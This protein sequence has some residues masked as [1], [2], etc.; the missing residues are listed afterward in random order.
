[1]IE[2][3]TGAVA[4]DDT[5][6]PAWHLLASTYERTK[7][8]AD[9]EA[10]YRRLLAI[11]GNDAVAL[12]SLAYGLAV[13]GH[14]PQEALPLATR[15]VA[16]APANA[17]MSDT[18]GWILHLLGKDQEALRLIEPASRVLRENAESQLHAAVSCCAGPA[19]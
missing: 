14:R 19:R 13:R 15:A 18:L 4:L 12:N 6:R 11:D 10:A 1:M 2:A 5:F 9:A 8:Y 7:R 17:F 16:L 3:L